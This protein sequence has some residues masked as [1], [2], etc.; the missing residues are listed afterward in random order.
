KHC[1]LIAFATFT[2]YGPD[3]IG[4]GSPNARSVQV[5]YLPC[6]PIGLRVILTQSGI[7]GI[8]RIRWFFKLPKTRFSDTPR[9]LCDEASVESTIGV[10][11]ERGS[12]CPSG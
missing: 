12:S 11:Q 3:R 10:P 7:R 9:R 2:H 1:P 6:L 4:I 8:I 5:K